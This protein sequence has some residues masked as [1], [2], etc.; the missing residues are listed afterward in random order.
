MNVQKID[1]KTAMQMVLEHHYTGRKVGSKSSFGLFLDDGTLVGC[2]V[3][4][5]PASYTLCKGVCG[6]ALKSKV[7]ELSR[8]VVATNKKNAASFLVGQSL[9]QIGDAIVVS[10]AD[11]SQGGH[12]GYVYQA[13]NWIYTGN[14]TA[15]PAWVH[16]ETGKVI[17]YTRRHIDKKAA[18]M[19][20]HWNQLVRVPQKGKHRYVIFCGTRRFKKEASRAL[21]YQRKP[22]PKGETRRHYR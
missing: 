15:E 14:G 19:G 3:Y 11:I 20:L 21:K 2:C 4:S 6:E 22:Y 5:I 18:R 13:T 9:R 12:V 16:P 10:Y 8:L 17:S 1:S 7:L